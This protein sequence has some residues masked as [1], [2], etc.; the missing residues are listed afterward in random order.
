MTSAPLGVATRSDPS[1]CPL[2]FYL[3]F[4]GKTSPRF[5]CGTK[6]TPYVHCEYALLDGGDRGCESGEAP[7]TLC[8]VVGQRRG[9]ANPRYR[10]Q[11]ESQ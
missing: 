1:L 10:C 3:F 11:K 6:E 7:P 9:G 4:F 5:H 8:P 2:Y